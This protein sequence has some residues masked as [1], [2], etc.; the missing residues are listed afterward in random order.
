MGE[1][2]IKPYQV[3]WEGPK[4]RH[5]LALEEFYKAY[6]QAKPHEFISRENSEEFLK[7]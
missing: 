7:K 1:N 5:K 6:P 2:G 3:G 4:E